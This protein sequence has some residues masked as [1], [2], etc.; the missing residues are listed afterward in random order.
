MGKIEK[1]IIGVLLIVIGLILSL[2]AL[3]ITNIN[4]FFKG[5]WT[6]FIIIPSII[7]LFKDSDKIGNLIGLAVGISL[8]F[9]FNDIFT[10]SQ[11]WKI[12]LPIVLIVIGLYFII[13]ETTNFSKNKR[14]EKEGVKL[15]SDYNQYASFSSNKIKVEEKFEG[16]NLSATF[17]EIKLD[18]TNAKINKDIYIK[19]STVFGS[20]EIIIPD[21]IK[22]DLMSSAI[23]GD[24]KDKKKIKEGTEMLENKIHIDGNAV[25]G[26]VE[27]R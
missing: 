27:I 5:W 23:F 18:L 13:N 17:G 7:G 14:I 12:G 26:E 11:I 16:A 22:V 19:A 8:L 1:I 24:V 3:G 15:S 2:N 6:L 21:N 9:V 20:I 4:I 10:Y 25:F